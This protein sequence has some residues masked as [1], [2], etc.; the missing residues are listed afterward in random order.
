[1]ALLTNDQAAAIDA[2]FSNALA[3]AGLRVGVTG[4]FSLSAVVNDVISQGGGV[5]PLPD[6]LEPLGGALG[7][8][9][10]SLAASGTDTN[11]SIAITPQGSGNVQIP[12]ALAITGSGTAFSVTNNASVGG[13]LLSTGAITAS[14]GVLTNSIGASSSSSVSVYGAPVDAANAIGTLV[15]SS[16]VLANASAKLLSI[17]N[18]S[19]EKAFFDKNGTLTTLGGVNALTVSGSSYV[20][21]PLLYG[22]G[23]VVNIQGQTA[24]GASAVGVAL[25]NTITLANGTAKLVSIQN[26]SVEKWAFMAG[27]AILPNADA[28]QNL[29]ATGQ[30]LGTVYA[31]S[32]Q[33]SGG[34]IVYN[35]VGADIISGGVGAGNGWSIR[36]G[37]TDG[38]TAKSLVV[39]SANALSNTAARLISVQNNSA[40]KFG[41]DPN[42]TTSNSGGEVKAYNSQSG[43]SYSAASSDR[44]IA[45]S[46]DAIRTVT[47]P[48]AAPAG[49]EYTIQDTSGSVN[50][51]HTVTVGAASGSV[52]SGGAATA[53]ITPGA[54]G[55]ISVFSDGTNYWITAKT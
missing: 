15:G 37:D 12:S 26:N 9:L 41:V 5:P 38:A 43:T 50:A 30:R 32:F 55:S 46:N 47:L 4:L 53:V 8:N 35:N 3:A 23:A 25:G 17:K 44:Y 39:N 27:G 16:T 45:M 10:V 31:N 42:G 48:G 7:S 1:M 11:I 22:A 19:T 18:S 21:S 40:E 14:S 6:V 34:G 28:S 54:S 52:K 33:V 49:T 13:T 29:G 51:T 2:A 36:G 24:D 20:Q